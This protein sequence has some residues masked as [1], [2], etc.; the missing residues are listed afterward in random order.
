MRATVSG[1]TGLTV[2]AGQEVLAGLR[3]P[4][5]QVELLL[6][7]N[8]EIGA[9]ITGCVHKDGPGG[10]LQL[11]AERLL[12]EVF[13]PAWNHESKICFGIS[14]HG[15]AAGPRPAWPRQRVVTSILDDRFASA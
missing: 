11:V 2:A 13:R 12:I 10:D 5:E 15:D 9:S 1:N 3:A 14:K 7:G 4:I 6:P 8:V